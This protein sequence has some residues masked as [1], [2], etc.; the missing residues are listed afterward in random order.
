MKKITLFIWL[1][2][3]LVLFAQVTTS[4]SPILIDQS[5]TI[6]IDANSS[7]TDCNGF[8]N[9]S[10]IYAHLGVGN[11]TDEYGISVVGNWGQDDGVGLMTDMGG[12]MYSITFTPNTYF[13]LNATEQSQV[14]KMGMV[15]RNE[16][17]SQEFKDNGCTN[18]IFNVGAFQVTMINPNS[19]GLILVNS[20]GQTQ[21]IAQNTNGAANYELFIDGSSFHTATT[22]FYQSALI[23]NITENKYCELRVTQSG[24]TIS[25]FF[26]ILV[27]GTTTQNLPAGMEN[28]INYSTD[29]T[30][31]TLV[32]DAPLKD[33]VYVAGS[34]NN[35]EPTSAHAM[36]K[37]ATT[38][39]FW[40]ELTGLTDGE[41]ETYQYWVAD[42]TPLTDS[43]KL[44]K[45]F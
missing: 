27:N 23:T 15:F 25:K 29:N 28:G 32:L 35:W 38:G 17:G 8:S 19:S 10:K 42:Q 24:S 33:F 1:L 11:D 13:N 36:K 43:P 12:G 39:K 14:T 40:L 21:I 45:T 2:L 16:D 18:F 44:V 4:P 30:V 6:T 22:T 5:L 20:G 3:P 26:T 31:A 37:D 9:P 41:I 34:F 7:D